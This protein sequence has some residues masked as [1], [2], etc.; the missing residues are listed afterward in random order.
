[1]RVFLLNPPNPDQRRYIREGRCTQE[2]GVWTTVWPPLSLALAAA[3]L[4]EAGHETRVMDCPAEGVGMP[5]AQEAIA[6]FAPRAV[7]WSTGTPSLQDD[8]AFSASVKAISPDIRTAVFGTSV[9]ALDTAC[10]EAARGIDVIVRDE[11]ELTIAALAQTLAA[12]R[13]LADVQGIT[14]RAADGSCARNPPRPFASDLDSLPFPAWHKVRRECYRLPLKGAPFLL[15]APSRGCPHECIY[16]TAQNYYGSRFRWRSVPNVIAE[17]QQN[18]TAFGVKDIFFWSDTFTLN[19]KYVH[20]LCAGIR[21][22]RL[23]ISWVC[24]SR[25]DTIDEELAQAMSAAGCAMISFGIESG[26]QDILD[27]SKKRARVAD[28]YTAVKAAKKA[29]IRT[30]GHFI[31]G[32]PGETEET[33][34]ETMALSRDLGLDLAQFYTAAPYPGSRLY[35]MAQAEG[36]LDDSAQ[37]EMSQTVA[38]LN[39]PSVSP[40][41]VQEMRRQAFRQFYLRPRILWGIASQVRMQGVSQMVPRSMIFY[42]WLAR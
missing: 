4:E 23:P 35:T 32:L 8:L 2:S 13:T 27:R 3:L 17:L 7:V 22:H 40:Q 9:S 1:M 31:L 29:G 15:V 39:L 18:L 11:P 5:A 41:R 24:N 42:R 36:W 12:G 25:V 21:R 37:R 33:A 10:L 20:E 14:Y 26:S 6:A 38:S 34:Q 19:R 16:C 30:V 28:A